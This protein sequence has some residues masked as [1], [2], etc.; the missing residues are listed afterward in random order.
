MAQMI[1]TTEF[2]HHLQLEKSI[3]HLRAPR[4]LTY[5]QWKHGRPVLLSIDACDVHPID[6]MKIV[7]D[8]VE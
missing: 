7:D 3:G 6:V 4:R 2:D 1:G 8:L 5:V